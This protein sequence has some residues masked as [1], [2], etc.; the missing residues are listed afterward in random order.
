MSTISKS[1]G[2]KNAP[3][4]FIQKKRAEALFK[5]PERTPFYG[6][7]GFPSAFNLFLLFQELIILFIQDIPIFGQKRTKALKRSLHQA[8]D[9]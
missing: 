9:A 2:V 7:I 8:G 3:T 1:K 6:I 5:K 4:T